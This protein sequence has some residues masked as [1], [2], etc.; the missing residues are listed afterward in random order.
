ML[1]LPLF[2]HEEITPS[3]LL[4]SFDSTRARF[5]ELLKGDLDFHGE[6]S[7][8]IHRIHPFPAKFP[9]ALP[10]LFIQHLTRPGDWV[11]DPMMGSGT[12]VV[13]AAYTG[14]VALGGDIDPLALEVARAKCHP[15]P[16]HRLKHA[17][18]R[19]LRRAESLYQDGQTL[20]QVLEARFDA[21]TRR[22]LDYWFLRNTQRELLALQQSVEQEENPYIKTWLRV[23]FSGIIIAKG[24]SVSL[25]RDLSHTRPHRVN[26]VPRSALAAFR[27]R[28][29]RMVQI[30]SRTWLDIPSHQCFV[31]QGDAQR[32]PLP[33]NRVRLIVTSP[34]YA[35]NAIDYMRAHKFT[36]VWWGYPLKALSQLRREYIGG[37]TTQGVLLE[38]LPREA[39]HA[40]QRIA[41]RDAK[42]GRVLHR[43]FSE[44]RR[45]L[46][47][48]AR[49]L[50]PG[51]CAVIVVGDSTMRGTST[52]IPESLMAIGRQ[53]GLEWV[54][55]GIRRLDR[56]RRMM[57]TRHQPGRSQIERRMHHEYVLGF[58]KPAGAG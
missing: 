37:E 56:D 43:Y 46:V 22:F 38:P 51:G 23:V 16:P 14:R 33:S 32:L 40:V 12:T 58:I 31:W 47:E 54:H 44:M 55:T 42:K 11:L 49:V 24:G 21:E 28:G 41:A 19:V 7:A 10:R 26:K 17:I 18:Y 29:L 50:Q 13:E 45:V 52:Q 8:A 57:P 5:S 1:R 53:V 34:P 20:Q 48:M 2:P 25:A 36:L 9:P 39:Q 6:D 15:V 35:S 27:E 4:S 30:L 3:P